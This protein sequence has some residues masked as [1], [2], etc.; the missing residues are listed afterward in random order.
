[1]TFA[2]V[3][4]SQASVESW[5]LISTGHLLHII[6]FAENCCSGDAEGQSGGH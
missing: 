5:Q 3:I 6:L 2:A 1:M 4:T